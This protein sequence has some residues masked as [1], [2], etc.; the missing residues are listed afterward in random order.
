V[1]GTAVRRAS[2]IASGEVDEG[3]ER[4]AGEVAATTELPFID[5]TSH[6]RAALIKARDIFMVES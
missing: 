5:E 1:N 4:D 6:P 2:E 3:A